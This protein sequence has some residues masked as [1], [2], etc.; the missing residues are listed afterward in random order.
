MKVFR[1]DETPSAAHPGRYIWN[2][3]SA[4]G[5]S[6]SQ[7]VKSGIAR[8]AAEYGALEP[9]VHGE[10][11][12]YVISADRGRVRFGESREK[13]DQVL[14]LETGMLIHAPAGEWHVFEY[15]QGGHIEIVYFLLVDLC[16]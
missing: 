7:K 11:V 13:M 15:D 12:C 5:F 1:R 3:V 4:D 10:E 16:Q 6:T 2:A 14:S 8:Y 9:H